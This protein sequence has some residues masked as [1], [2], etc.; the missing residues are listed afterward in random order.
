MP[1]DVIV[2]NIRLGTSGL[3]TVYPTTTIE[4]IKQSLKNDYLQFDETNDILISGTTLLNLIDQSDFFDRIYKTG[5]TIWTKSSLKMFNVI[6]S[7]PSQY[8]PPFNQVSNQCS[9]ISS[10]VI[11]CSKTLVEFIKFREMKKMVELYMDCMRSGTKSRETNGRLVQGENIDEIDKTYKLKKTIYGSSDLLTFLPSDVI[12]MI[13]KPSIPSYP[14]TSFIK[15]I[16][17]MEIGQGII[18]NRDGKTFV[19]V[20]TF[21][22]NFC[23]FDSHI[24]NILFYP[25]ELVEN[26]ILENNPDGFFY[27]I[28][29]VV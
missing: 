13:E 19:I 21:C 22:G 23:I 8:D 14:Y 26:Y 5:I 25:F 29:S 16:Q 15:E 9:W 10:K 18:I 6:A 27:I 24:R 17:N 4:T 1:F 20:K 12:D 3:I 28:W 7:V 2:K 11:E